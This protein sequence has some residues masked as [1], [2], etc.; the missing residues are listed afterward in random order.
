MATN[1]YLEFTLSANEG[2]EIDFDSLSVDLQMAGTLTNSP[3]SWFV[4]SSLD[5][6]GTTI[7]TVINPTQGFETYI[8]DLSG[9]SY[10]NVT[11]PITFRLYVYGGVTNSSSSLRHDNLTVSGSVVPQEEPRKGT[12]IMISSIGGWGLLGLISVTFCRER[13]LRMFFSCRAV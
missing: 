6:Y 13:S 3:D 10:Q 11:E 12:I 2:Y 4:R 8:V 9:A 7:G 5:G 1:S